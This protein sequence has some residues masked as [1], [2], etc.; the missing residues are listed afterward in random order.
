MLVQFVVRLELLLLNCM[1]CIRLA[2]AV[3]SCFGELARKQKR[4]NSTELQSATIGTYYLLITAAQFHIPFYS[5]RL[6]PNTFALLLVTN[7]YADWFRGRHKLAA[8]YL[9]FTAGIFRCDM[10]LLLFTVG[11]CMLIRRQLTILEALSVGV[12]TGVIGLLMTVPLDSVLWGRPIWPEFEV[13]WFNTV[14]NRSSEWGE[15]VWHWYFSRALPKGLMCTALLIPLA[16]VRIPELVAKM[17]SN[18]SNQ[19]MQVQQLF[20]CGIYP[21]FA[22]VLAFVVM[23]SFLPH[24]E[25]R[26]IF[27]AIPM[28]NVGAAY[29]M[30]RLHQCNFYAVT[31]EE[32]Q[33]SNWVCKLMY[34]CG[35]GT[36]M[37]TSVASMLF[38]RISTENY[39]GG[40]AL[41]RL[42]QYLL[43]TIPQQNDGKSGWNSVRLHVDVA[44][45]MTG[46]SLFGQRHASIRQVGSEYYEGPFL[47]DKSGYEEENKAD[48]SEMHPFT[49]LLT[50]KSRV[51][52]FRLID[53]IKGHPRLDIRK[54]R[55]ATDDAI[56]IYEKDD[57]RH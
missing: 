1:A 20:D 52:G 41:L 24:K 43:N 53:V 3:D 48:E 5:S 44:A 55:I 8:T 31:N 25:I 22:P 21:Y 28:F 2:R 15:M 14:D 10:L 12:A 19:M 57:W 18:K 9:V 37:L 42:R 27:P 34:L 39:P 17:A 40:E 4:R 54:L 46:V 36:I 13:W 32:Q 16:F 30:S 51:D 50:E 26:F 29:G 35:L 6:L 33:T 45:A 11:L 49:H 7:A 47:I 23:Y 56:F 38:L